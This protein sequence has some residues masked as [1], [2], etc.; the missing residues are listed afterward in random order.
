MTET[1]TCLS[2][3]DQMNGRGT[4]VKVS[5]ALT[6]KKSSERIGEARALSCP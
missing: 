5:Q 3:T 1:E 4:V 6:H 2:T